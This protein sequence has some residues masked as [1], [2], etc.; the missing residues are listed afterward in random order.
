MAANTR[1]MSHPPY[2]VSGPLWNARHSRPVTW[3]RMLVSRPGSD[4]YCGIS[5]GG[6]D[7]AGGWFHPGTEVGPVAVDQDWPRFTPRSGLTGTFPVGAVSGG[8]GVLARCSST[9]ARLF[10]G[11]CA[12]ADEARDRTS[13]APRNRTSVAPRSSSPSERAIDR[14]IGSSYGAL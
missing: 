9:F 14:G 7:T 5:L 13:A 12:N 8:G 1:A 10:E 4:A 11:V 2:W 3:M 6:F